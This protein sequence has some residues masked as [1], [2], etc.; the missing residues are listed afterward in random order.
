MSGFVV[1]VEVCVCPRTLVRT[2]LLGNGEN[3]TGDKYFDSQVG[4]CTVE[5]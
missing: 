1:V 4:H 3:S 2:Y 5:K